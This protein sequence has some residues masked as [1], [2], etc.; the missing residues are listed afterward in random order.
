MTYKHRPSRPEVVAARRRNVAGLLLR[1][2]TIHQIRATLATAPETRNPNTD[3]PWSVGTIHRDIKALDEEWR[4]TAS[5][6]VEQR[7][8]IQVTRIEEVI[9]QAWR[10]DALGTVLKALAHEAKLYGLYVP[11]KIAPTTPGG[12]GEYNRNPD[13]LEDAT[14]KVARILQKVVPKVLPGE[15]RT[16]TE[17]S[18]GDG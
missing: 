16:E 3:E 4:E 15:A 1:G 7:K 14:E 10:E 5:E 17:Q 11:T 8:S 18:G 12:M 6:E 9:K 13:T 2:F